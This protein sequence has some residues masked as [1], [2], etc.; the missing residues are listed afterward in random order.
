MLVRIEEGSLRFSRALG[1]VRLSGGVVVVRV[2]DVS[3]KGGLYDQTFI[4]YL[5]KNTGNN[6]HF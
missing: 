4:P 2:G 5:S 6:V 3:A 1:I